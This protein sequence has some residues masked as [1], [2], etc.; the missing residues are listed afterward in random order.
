MQSYWLPLLLLLLLCAAAAV[1]ARPQRPEPFDIAPD[2]QPDADLVIV[3][4]HYNEDLAWL[5]KSDY[6]TVVCSKKLPSPL[7]PV[8]VNEGYEVSS[9][10]SFIVHNYARL[11]AHVAFLH[12]HEKAGHQKLD[13]LKAISCAKHKQHGFISLNSDWCT[14]NEQPCWARVF[15]TVTR[16]HWDTLFRPFLNRDMPTSV[17]VDCCAQFIVSRERIL[18]I[19]LEAYQ[20]WLDFI[21]RPGEPGEPE[22]AAKDRAIMFESLW[23]I[24]FG[25]PDIMHE[26][27]HAAAFRCDSR[28][29]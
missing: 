23:H 11:P 17:S 20:A 3:T 19:P 5:R 29:S 21:T 6:P 25:E 24:I 26:R 22:S 12:G 4:S 15:G 18:R 27:E 10:L 1:S 7:C 13:V 16:K 8:A 9:Y 14:N 28:L 2:Y